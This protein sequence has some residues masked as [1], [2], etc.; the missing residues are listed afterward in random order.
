[1]PR[2]LALTL[3][4]LARPT[5]AETYDVV[6]YGATPGGIAAAL[7]LGRAERSVLL[8]DPTSRIGGMPTN[9]LNHPDFR[10]FEGI[11]GAFADFADCIL[12][13][14]T[15]EYGAD[16]KQVRT[17]LRGTHAEPG[18]ALK[19]FNAWLAEHPSIKVRTRWRLA[20]VNVVKDDEGRPTISSIVL[21]DPEGRENTIEGTLFIDGTY[22]G[23]LLAAAGVPFRVG[24]EGRDEYGESLAPEK[25]DEQVQGYNFRLTVTGDP[26]NRVL[27][28]PPPGYDRDDFEALLPLLADGRIKSAFHVTFGG[29]VPHAV[30]K[31]Q[32]PRLPNGKHDVNDMSRGRVRLSLPEISRSWPNGDHETRTRLFAEQM[33]HNVGLMYFLQNDEGVPEA[34]RKD[35]R[36]WGLCRD[37][38][39]DSDHLP[40]QLYVREARR[41]VGKTVFTQR[42]VAEASPT[43]PRAV[44]AADAIAMGDYGP[45]C[46]GTG[47]E[48]PRFGGRHTGEFYAPVAPYQIPYGAIVPKETTNLLAPVPVSSSHVGFCAL[49]LEPIWMSLGQA[50]G[51]AADRSLASKVAIQ[52]VD[53]AEIRER[54]HAVGAATI[55][56]SDVPR[57]SPHFAAVQWWGSVGG[58]HG[59]RERKEK[60]GQRG[61][62]RIGQYYEA[63]LGHTADLD[64]PLTEG[65]RERWLALAAKLELDPQPLE[66]AA[67]RGAFVRAAYRGR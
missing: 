36:E 57:T 15:A 27:P 47:H 13:H 63:F 58:L 40:V 41:M 4:L 25:A 29:S 17:T 32:E 64:E 59:L 21:L 37:E 2:L 62:N 66:R 56:V 31:V 55:Y 7:E 10:T 65:L 24:R 45:N 12:E 20:R 23:D 61:E 30:F 46:H 35:A 11:T 52:D 51:I 49:R 50:A 53:P 39:P 1:M 54:L 33:R 3:L 43:D 5:F 42:N 16:S 22:E 6:I 8:V 67:T 44:F 28:G 14:Y 48:G 18:V 19:V 60:Y 38:F 26:E 9:G 34:V